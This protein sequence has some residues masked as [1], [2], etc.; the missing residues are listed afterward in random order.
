M[1]MKELI[2][3][4][5]IKTQNSQLQKHPKM[6]AFLNYINEKDFKAIMCFTKS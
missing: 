4:L 5:G 6:I 1:T 3:I 2:K